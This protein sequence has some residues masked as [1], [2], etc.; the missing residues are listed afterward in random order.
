MLGKSKGGV[1]NYLLALEEIYLVAKEDGKYF[2]I[3]PL[4]G[5][6]ISGEEFGI[7]R[8]T[9]PKKVTDR[10]LKHPEEKYLRASIEPF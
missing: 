2:I 7:E 6:W 1:R 5:L 8:L 10:Y 9:F 3:D 4:I